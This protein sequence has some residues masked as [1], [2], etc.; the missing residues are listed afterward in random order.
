M[1]MGL[2]GRKKNKDPIN[3]ENTK[4]K[5]TLTDSQKDWFRKMGDRQRA[6]ENKANIEQRI[7]NE[8]KEEEEV[9]KDRRF[10]ASVMEQRRQ[11]DIKMGWRSPDEGDD[12][13]E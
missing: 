5:T 10:K 11:F 2:F 8:Q 13:L 1:I 3:L 4:P 12:E 7:L 9:E 6:R